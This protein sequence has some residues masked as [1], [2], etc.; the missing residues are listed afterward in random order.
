MTDNIR[1]LNIAIPSISEIFTGR[2]VIDS[3]S[4]DAIFLNTDTGNE[5]RRNQ[6]YLQN[7]ISFLPDT[8]AKPYKEALEQVRAAQLSAPALAT[9]DR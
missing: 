3:R 4:D 6:R 9:Y 7:K 5:V 1:P 8:E 2:V